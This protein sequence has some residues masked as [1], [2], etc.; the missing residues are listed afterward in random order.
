[1]RRWLAALL[2]LGACT[3]RVGDQSSTPP[4]D[5]A[6]A[7]GI[8]AG[9]PL[10]VQDAA[11][12]VDRQRIV[13]VAT[14]NVH[15][16]FDPI[17]DSGDCSQGFERA[18]SQAAFEQRAARLAA[19][20]ERLDADFLALEEIESQLCFDAIVAALR[21][22][23]IHYPVAVF[24]ET[25]APA[26]VDVAVLGRGELLST[27]RHRDTPLPLP[28][29]GTTTFARELLEV[30]MA[31]RGLTLDFFAAHFRSKNN[32]DPERRLA[33]AKAAGAILDAAARAR[34]SELIVL[35]GDLNDEPGSQALMAL[36]A[37]GTL[38]RLAAD[39]PIGE[40]GTYVYEGRS[41]AIDHLYGAGAT[42]AAYVPGSTLALRD[43]GGGFGES[44]HA[45]LRA[46]L[47]VP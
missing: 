32:D 15:L 21:A 1:M 6:A 11:P 20:L 3:D 2:L 38:L 33:E 27:E 26:S 16:F 12:P 46:D 41:Q 34:P 28:S 17:C 14:Y 5:A 19:T 44:D 7:P 9:A 13:R 24:G 23:G 30:R 37:P 47:A 43:A 39:L 25:G 10:P 29:G 31:Y 22:R 42:A 8:E 18:P 36:E 4:E 45:A 40:Q 35:G